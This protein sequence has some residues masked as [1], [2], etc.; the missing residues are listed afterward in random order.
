MDSPSPVPAN[1]PSTPAVYPLQFTGSGHEYFRIW[2]TNLLLTLITFG[3]YSPW[4]KVRREQY[5]H[6]NTQLDH[7]GFD[8]HGQPWAILKGRL[9]AWGLLLLL[10]TVDDLAPQWYFLAL[11]VLSPLLPWLILRSFV[12]RARNTSYRGLRFDFDGRYPEAAQIILGW[13]LLTLLTLG[14]TFPLFMQRLKN[15]QFRH[16]SFGGQRFRMRADIGGFYGAFLLVSLVIVIPLT[17]MLVLVA[18]AVVLAAG[19]NINEGL[20]GYFALAAAL[21]VTFMVIATQL[22]VLPFLQVRLS[23]LVWNHTTLGPHHF[24]SNQALRTLLPVFLGNWLLILLTF[25]LFWPWAKVRLAIYRA[26][27]T[28][29]LAN[30]SVDDFIGQGA[31]QKQALG[32]EI[33]DTFDLDIAL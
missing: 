10:A 14:L 28:R 33:A 11:L 9:I 6:R 20:A 7:S 15:F 18:I 24:A 27:H 22:L 13:G 25:G 12:F 4:A 26:D 2:V 32:E 17:V 31:M 8:Y 1:T 19:G 3:I 29:L 5:F 30:G 16:L 21:T 23:N